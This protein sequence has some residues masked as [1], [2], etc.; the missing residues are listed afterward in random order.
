MNRIRTVAFSVYVVLITIIV[1]VFGSPILLF[2]PGAMRSAARVWGNAALFGLAAICGVRH[3]IE[4]EE[5]I[6]SGPAIVAANHQSM[7]ETIAFCVLLPK[8]VMVF[9][10]ELLKVPVYGF[11]GRRAGIPVD[12]EGGAKAIRALT[13]A[14]RE[15]LNEGCQVVLFPEGTRFPLGERGE[16]QPGV[17]AIY[18]GAEVSCTPAVHDSGRCWLFPGG[19]TSLK[20]PGVI[21]LRFEPAIKPGL[22]RKTFIAELAKTLDAGAR[23]LARGNEARTPAAEGRAEGSA[24]A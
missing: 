10:K 11:W 1:G 20:A 13:K 14:A 18:A 22:P 15:R 21:T 5:H 12:R 3:R 24:L 8:P 19:L 6:P 16:L 2:G 9:K 23:D 7:W 17:A 4:G